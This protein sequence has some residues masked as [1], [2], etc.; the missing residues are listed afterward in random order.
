MLTFVGLGLY[1]EQSITVE[2]R[3]AIADADRV[4]A[5]FYTSRLS[6]ATV[7]DLEAAHGIDIEVRDRPGVEGSPDPI[8]T[9]PRP[10][11][12]SFSPPATR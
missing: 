10:A 2:G 4:F 6:G 12:P 8:W 3:E 5:E 11:R 9:P 7:A 1:D